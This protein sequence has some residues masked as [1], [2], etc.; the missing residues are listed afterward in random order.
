M[1]TVFESE[2]IRFVEVS[3][4]LIPDYLTMINDMENVQRF[5]PILEKDSMAACSVS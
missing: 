1:N 5:Q 4:E 2:N 3:E